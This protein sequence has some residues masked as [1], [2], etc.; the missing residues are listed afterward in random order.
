MEIA[1]LIKYIALSRLEK[2]FLWKIFVDTINIGCEGGLG[3]TSHVLHGKANQLQQPRF[4]VDDLTHFA[5]QAA[6]S[7]RS[8]AFLRS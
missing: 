4:S 8:I 5:L 1:L 7:H 6:A 2:V 3:S